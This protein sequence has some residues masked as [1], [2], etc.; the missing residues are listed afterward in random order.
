MKTELNDSPLSGIDCSFGHYLM[1]RRMMESRRMDGNGIP[2]Y[3][4]A[5]DHECRK[6]LDSIPNFYNTAKNVTGT[7]VS[8]QVQYY[9]RNAL[10]VGPAQFPEIYAIACTCA[11]TLGIGI[12]SV[13]VVNSAEMNAYTYA[14][15]D[16]SPIVVIYNGLIER[17]T[18]DELLFVIGHECGHIQNYHTTYKYLSSILLNVGTGLAGGVSRA[19]AS[20]MT[21]GSTV[22]LAT[23]SR[24][25][26]V[27][28][29]R[30]G[31]ICAG[32][33]ETS[34]SALA[35]I[36]YGGRITES[37]EI[38]YAEIR[39]Q[40]EQTMSNFSKYGEILDSH[41]ATARRIAAV[42][43]FA[44]CSLFYE[45]REDQKRPGAVARTKEDTD[46]RCR[47][48]IDLSKNG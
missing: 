7:Y 15:D 42:Q 38:D 37:A 31:L 17:M 21:V 2:N 14:T 44:E 23:W 41:P 10:A 8:R 45:W 46:M 20:L 5:L 34:C 36:M 19:L 18:Q 35:K 30:A 11:K 9:N 40:L 1:R 43:E 3:A 32:R 22:A 47:R 24:A 28:A 26:E 16:V 4:F 48:Y 29:D 39:R 27:T 12:P 25:A 33:V 6:K 13:F